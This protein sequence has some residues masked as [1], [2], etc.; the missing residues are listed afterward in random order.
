MENL[1][2]KSLIIIVSIIK[3]KSEIARNIVKFS[4]HGNRQH[5]YLVL[6]IK[7]C[8]ASLVDDDICK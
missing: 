6:I 1:C 7:E 8:T 3:C 4:W 2:N 5:F